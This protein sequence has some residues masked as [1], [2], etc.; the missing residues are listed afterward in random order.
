MVSTSFLFLFCCVNCGS[1]LE[2]IFILA[3]KHAKKH[4]KKTNQFVGFRTDKKN[5]ND[6]VKI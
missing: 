4:K 6:P 1:P 3:R 2:I 5:K